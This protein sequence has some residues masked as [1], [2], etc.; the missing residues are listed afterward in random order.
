MLSFLPGPLLGAMSF[1]LMLLN[2]LILCPI[3]IFFSF[4]KMALPIKAWQTFWTKILIFIA[5]T[6]ISN[7]NLAIALMHKIEWD[8]Q[9]LENL[10]RNGWYLVNCNHQSWVD[11]VILQKVFRSQIPFLKFFLKKELIW[12][13]FLGV[14]WWAL[15]FPFMKRYTKAEIE[16]N[17]NLKGKDLETTQKA[18]EKF[19]YTPVSVMNFLEGTRFTPAKHAKQE[20]PFTHL[21]KP[22]AGGVAFVLSAMSGQIRSMIDVTIVYHDKD[23]EMWDL[24]TGKIKKV[25][26]HIK[27]REIPNEMLE[28]NYED[29]PAF[30]EAFQTWI[31]N[32]WQEKDQLID[33]L[34]SQSA[35]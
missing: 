19:K 27:Q 1:S 30:R 29:D 12:V 23:I 6:W 7:N 25:T 24:L 15:D 8:I 22:K 14:C 35:L 32:I 20:S 16:K 9:G 28:G 17:P 18:C 33:D 5:E 4:F 13:P 26:V 2:I 34:K 11:I 3:L 21:L 10:D 31:S